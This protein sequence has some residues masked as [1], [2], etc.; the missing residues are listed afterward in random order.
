MI[1]LYFMFYTNMD[2]S[3]G[4]KGQGFKLWM[5]KGIYTDIDLYNENKL[6]PLEEFKIKLHRILH[7]YK[8]KLY[9]CMYTLQYTTHTT[10]N[11]HLRLIQYNWIME[12]L[13]DCC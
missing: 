1:L 7:I 10:V 6:L 5:T 12:D 9:L 4:I 3:P 2:F 13:C 8:K 11:L